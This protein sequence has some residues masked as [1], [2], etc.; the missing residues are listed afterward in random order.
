MLT[1]SS[2]VNV[3]RQM[4]THKSN[5]KAAGR[6][7]VPM[8]LTEFMDTVMLMLVHSYFPSNDK[9]PLRVH[10]ANNCFVAAGRLLIVYICARNKCASRAASTAFFDSY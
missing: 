1:H 7:R 9:A 6:K 10:A 2:N 8:V 3:T 4:L 5:V